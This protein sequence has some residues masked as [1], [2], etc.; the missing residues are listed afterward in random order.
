MLKIDA[1]GEERDTHSPILDTALQAQGQGQ[2][3]SRRRRSFGFS[4]VALGKR[5]LPQMAHQDCSQAAA[6][7]VS[8]SG[9]HA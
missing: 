2:S 6:Q 5:Q 8:M 7:G 9:A 1:E 3:L 4:A